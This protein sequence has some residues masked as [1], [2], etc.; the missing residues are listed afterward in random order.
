[1]CQQGSWKSE[2]SIG[3]SNSGTAIQIYIFLFK[4][5]TRSYNTNL[6]RS[7]HS[8]IS[9]TNS[10]P[11]NQ[12]RMV[13]S[14]HKYFDSVSIWLGPSTLGNRAHVASPYEHCWTDTWQVGV[15]H[16]DWGWHQEQIWEMYPIVICGVVKKTQA[17]HFM[18]IGYDY[19]Y[20][21]LQLWVVVR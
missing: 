18:E 16:R 14:P 1:M 8:Q 4:R 2:S 12:I 15:H 3:W 21:F 10:K 19:S 13:R 11:P 6:I 5:F 20:M 9:Y 7:L 17:A